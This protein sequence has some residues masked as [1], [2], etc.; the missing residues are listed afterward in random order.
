MFTKYRAYCFCNQ[1]S[2]LRL[3]WLSAVGCKLQ[4]RAPAAA[5]V[6]CFYTAYSRNIQALER[7]YLYKQEC[8]AK[9]IS[10]QYSPE[11]AIH[12]SAQQIGLQHSTLPRRQIVSDIIWFRR[13]LK[14]INIIN[15][16]N[17]LFQFR[18]RD[19]WQFI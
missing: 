18:I 2:R 7:F 16:N 12:L 4:Q 13:V 3:S 8:S 17:S 19:F 11:N 15:F 6:G 14:Y 9:F 10:C 1:L 5:A